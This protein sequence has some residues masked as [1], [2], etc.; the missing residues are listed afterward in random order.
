VLGSIYNINPTLNKKNPPIDIYHKGDNAKQYFNLD[1]GGYTCIESDYLY[2]GF[3]GNLSVG[4]Y[5]VLGNVGSYSIVLKPPFILP[6]FAVID[7]D[8]ENENI[9][10]IKEPENFE[11]I[12]HTYK[13]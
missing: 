1:F 12:F 8:D 3:N 2:K 4:D 13:F 9:E 11:D 7:Y 6:N 10:L 5:V